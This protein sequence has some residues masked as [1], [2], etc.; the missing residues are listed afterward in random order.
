[1]ARVVIVGGGIGGI[2]QAIALQREGIDDYVILERG[3][4]V[5]GTW[6]WNT[7]PGLACDV[8][9][10]AYSFSFAPNPNWSRR[11][12]PGPEIREYVEDVARRHGVLEKVRYGTEVTRAAWDDAGGRWQFDPEG[13]ETTQDEVLCPQVDELS[14]PAIP[15]LQGLARFGGAMF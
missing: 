7:Y 14:R 1:M 15:P 12:S 8:P 5:G 10:H 9:S 11:F 2:A 4:R 13:S 6:Q 3:E